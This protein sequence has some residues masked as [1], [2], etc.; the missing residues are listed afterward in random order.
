M[1]NIV[2]VNARERDLLGEDCIVCSSG[3]LHEFGGSDVVCNTCYAVLPRWLTKAEI[4]GF[5]AEGDKQ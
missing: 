3:K 5:Q 4:A 2:D 1:P